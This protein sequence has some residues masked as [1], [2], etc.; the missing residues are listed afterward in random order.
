MEANVQGFIKRPK[1]VGDKLRTSIRGDVGENS[2]LRK[3][4]EEEEFSQLWR[5]D[6]IVCRDKNTLFGEMIYDY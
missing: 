4:I 3:D 2:M 6:C 5:S 1:K